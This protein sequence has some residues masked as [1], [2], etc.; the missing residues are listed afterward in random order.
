[1]AKPASAAS[2]VSAV[3]VARAIPIQIARP[4]TM[5]KM[6]NLTFLSSFSVDG[7]GRIFVLLGIVTKSWI[8][9]IGQ[10]HPQGARPTKIRIIIIAPSVK[11]GNMPVVNVA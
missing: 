6:Y 5:T 11:N 2:S 10:I 7:D 8:V 4:T 9:P 3:P 1:M